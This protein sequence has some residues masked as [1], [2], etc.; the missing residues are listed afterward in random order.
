MEADSIHAATERRLKNKKINVPTN[1]V[2]VCRQDRKSQPYALKYLGRGFF[3]CSEDNFCDNIRPRR[4]IGD[5][6]AIDIRAFRYLQS[7]I[8]QYE[9]V[10]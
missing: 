2:T 10:F 1:Y 8:V 4:S 5:P 6:Q 9:L 3:K 7:G